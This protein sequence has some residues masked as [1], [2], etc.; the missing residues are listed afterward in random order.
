MDRLFSEGLLWEYC[1]MSTRILLWI[2]KGVRGLK[3]N[4]MMAKAVLCNCSDISWYVKFVMTFAAL[5]F[6]AFL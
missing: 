1:M 5:A 3:S 6:S 2:A 4:F